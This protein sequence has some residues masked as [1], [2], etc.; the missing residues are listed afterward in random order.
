MR[1]GIVPRHLTKSDLEFLVNEAEYFGITELIKAINSTP[2]NSISS[3]DPIT[4]HKIEHIPDHVYEFGV[5][6]QENRIFHFDTMRGYAFTVSKPMILE[7]TQLLVSGEKPFAG[8][9][10]LLM[11]DE[12]PIELQ[13]GTK[14]SDSTYH[15]ILYMILFNNH[16]Y[17][18]KVIEFFLLDPI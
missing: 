11:G 3:S 15:L 8:E 16:Y 4:V 9:A 7:S 10:T 5:P 17:N 14:T 12:D 2:I 18:T 13:T 6:K 1:D